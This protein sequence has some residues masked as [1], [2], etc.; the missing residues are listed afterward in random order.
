M[1]NIVFSQQMVDTFTPQER[2]LFNE[3]AE[4]AQATIEGDGFD[5]KAYL[6]RLQ[7]K[8]KDEE[9]YRQQMEK[10]LN[11]GQCVTQYY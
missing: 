2:E 8:Q 10:S 5:V 6:S 3:L 7:A 9:A 1:S 11:S 4:K